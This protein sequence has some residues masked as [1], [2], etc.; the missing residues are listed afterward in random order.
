M[1]IDQLGHGNRLV[2]VFKIDIESGEYDFF[3]SLFTAK[4]SSF[5]RQVLVEIHP[6]DPKQIHYFFE[7]FRANQY[8]IFSKEPNLIAGPTFFE[9]AFLRLGAA[10]FE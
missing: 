1:I 4:A 5:P 9:Y 2:D 10:F 3:A 6:R 7:S 8:V